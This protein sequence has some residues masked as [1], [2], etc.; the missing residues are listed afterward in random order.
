MIGLEYESILH[1]KLH[2]RRIPFLTEDALRQRGDAKTPDAL[3]S[4]PLLVHG[5]VVNWID[6]KATFG[7]PSSHLGY[8]KSQYSAY[9]RRFDSGLVI[10]WFGF[11]DS[12]DDD[13]RL[14]IL[15]AFPI[16]CELMACMPSRRDGP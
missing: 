4:V 12:I 3:L 2:A 16:D 8:H 9:L 10:Y 14:L 15:Q 5:R 13:P 1:Q 11:D 6:S 7:D